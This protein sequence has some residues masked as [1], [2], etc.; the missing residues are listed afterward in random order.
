M[1]KKE[2]SYDIDDLK[3]KREAIA[4]DLVDVYWEMKPSK[5]AGKDELSEFATLARIAGERGK[6][7]MKAIEKLDDLIA[8]AQQQ[9]P[10]NEVAGLTNEEIKLLMEFRKNGKSKS[11]STR[12]KA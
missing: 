11:T 6:I 1:A 10:I 7:G 2:K 4:L 9:K 12:S 3:K 5:F 8:Q